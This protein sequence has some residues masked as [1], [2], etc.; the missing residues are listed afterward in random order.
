MRFL[1]FI[2]ICSTFI[3][4]SSSVS[5]EL[6]RLQQIH[7]SQ[8]PISYEECFALTGALAQPLPGAVASEGQPPV[9]IMHALFLAQGRGAVQGLVHPSGPPPVPSSGAQL[10]LSGGG[11]TTA[12]GASSSAVSLPSPA[13]SVPLPSS[14]LPLPPSPPWVPGP[15]FGS[16]GAGPSSSGPSQSHPLSSAELFR[17]LLPAMPVGHPGMSSGSA[18]PGASNHQL[19]PAFPPNQPGIPGLAFIPAHQGSHMSPSPSGSAQAAGSSVADLAPEP[20]LGGL[21]TFS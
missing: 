20:G 7:A 4:L 12:P 13:G 5:P 10:P 16:L 8:L 18:V 9:T 17:S 11:V 1:L 21:R 3:A 19:H 2:L 6:L 14:S 15:M